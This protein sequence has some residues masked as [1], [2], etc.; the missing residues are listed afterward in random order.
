MPG[1]FFEFAMLDDP[2]LPGVPDV[3]EDEEDDGLDVLAVVDAD[4]LVVDF[5]EDVAV[6]AC[7][8]AALPPTRTPETISAIAA[9]LSVCRIGGSPPSESMSSEASQLPHAGRSLGGT[10]EASAN[11]RETHERA[12]PPWVGDRPVSRVIER[13]FDLR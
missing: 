8:I 2:E 9:F 10:G 4:V 13:A 3:P 1:Q 12:S 5:A 11:Q 6:A 7:A